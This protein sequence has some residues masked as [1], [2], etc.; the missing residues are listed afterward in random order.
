MDALPFSF[1]H[2]YAIYVGVQISVFHNSE[3]LVYVG[4]A[5][6]TFFRHR[7]HL[8]ILATHIINADWTST[9]HHH[10]TTNPPRLS[11]NS[12]KMKF[13]FA[14]IEWVTAPKR[15]SPQTPTG[16]PTSPAHRT[17]SPQKPKNKPSKPKDPPNSHK[18]TF[19]N[20]NQTKTYK[21][22][23]NKLKL[24]AKSQFCEQLAKRSN[25]PAINIY[26]YNTN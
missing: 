24:F 17:K 25:T 14:Q 16:Q 12:T 6:K 5:D 2:P 9:T 22:T 8:Q 20:T 26:I 3:Q 23:K 4:I 15:K 1:I 19:S 18:R 7:Q 11:S 10:P 13:F 21:N